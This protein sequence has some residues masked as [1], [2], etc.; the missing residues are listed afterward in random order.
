MPGKGLSNL[1]K[2]RSVLPYMGVELPLPHFVSFGWH[3]HD[4]PRAV[5][6]ALQHRCHNSSDYVHLLI[7]LFRLFYP[8]LAGDYFLAGEVAQAEE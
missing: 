6:F 7:Q 4:Q 1:L 2:K 8:F 3:E 5:M